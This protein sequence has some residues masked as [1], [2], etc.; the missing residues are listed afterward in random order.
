MRK[1][2]LSLFLSAAVVPPA[3]SA[4]T[5]VDIPN[6]GQ[7]PFAVPATPLDPMKL[8]ELTEPPGVP[9]E[10]PRP[11]D[12]EIEGLKK[13]AEIVAIETPP[14]SA[15]EDTADGP[16]P[17][18]ASF[19]T[20]FRGF[21]SGDLF[22]P[23]PNMA[24]GLDDVVV[25]VNS[26]FRIYDKLGDLGD[27]P[28]EFTLRNWFS[29]VVPT[30]TFIGD[31]KVVYDSASDRFI[32][33]AM[34]CNA[35]GCAATG[36]RQSWWLISVSQTSRA[37]GSWWN[38]ALDARL[39]GSTMTN[40]WADYPGL[41]LDNLAVYLTANMFAF[42]GGSQYAKIRI[43]NKSVLYTGGSLG[44]WDFW[45]LCNPGGVP[46]TC[47]S[48]PVFGCGIGGSGAFTIQPA[49]TYGAPG[50]EFLINANGGG[51][52]ALNR[53]TLTNPLG[54][55]PSLTCG[56][57]GVPGYSPPPGA[58]QQG[59]GTRLDTSDARLFNAVFRNG[60]LWTAHTIAV[61]WGDGIN[62]AGARWYEIIPASGTAR[63]AQTFG[64][65][66]F[67]YFYPAVVPDRFGNMVMVFSRSGATEFVSVRFAGRKSTDGLSTLRGSNLL[68]AGS[69]NYVVLDPGGRNRW[70][71][72]FGV[73]WDPDF[74]I[75]DFMW[76]FGEYVRGVNTSG[77]WLGS[78]TF[79]W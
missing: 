24:V 23:D 28:R 50:A 29:N 43:L 45:N 5:T 18:G 65:T 51:A 2:L 72:Y 55:P 3:E 42:G 16:G 77:T 17:T 15:Q 27:V 21:D 41:G 47:F 48:Q 63:Q 9:E 57:I 53:W 79:T 35:A 38:W 13:L 75:G 71:D 7:S 6:T 68:V 19:S 61:N 11:M 70:G 54:T 22:P 39:D 74:F 14:G 49:H 44:W 30:T 76:V 66:G 33:I 40:N 69:A 67:H 60:S 37:T 8:A 59:G 26:R 34:A 46:S 25:T 73:G 78:F 36:T 20:D 12:P 10:D 4:T 32:L 58:V 56:N 62:V 64:S 52:S 31:P 1:L